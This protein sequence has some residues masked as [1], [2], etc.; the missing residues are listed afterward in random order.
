MPFKR[1]GNIKHK[2]KKWDL[3]HLGHQTLRFDADIYNAY[4]LKPGS[5]ESLLFFVMAQ[6]SQRNA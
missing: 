5:F 1:I 3:F 4:V 6:S 2:I